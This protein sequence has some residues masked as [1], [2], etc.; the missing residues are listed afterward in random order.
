MFFGAEAIFYLDVFQCGVAVNTR[1]RYI[2]TGIITEGSE[3]ISAVL[4][5]S[6][7]YW[8]LSHEGDKP[9]TRKKRTRA[10]VCVCVYPLESQGSS[11]ICFFTESDQR[12]VPCT[13]TLV[14][15]VLAILQS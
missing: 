10:G 9:E 12:G 13:C 1:S 2:R 8:P 3:V 14:V 7:I 11:R 5:V 6:G 4:F 15:N